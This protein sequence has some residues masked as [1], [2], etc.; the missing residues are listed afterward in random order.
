MLQQEKNIRT[1]VEALMKE[2]AQRLQQLK[3]LLEQDQ[4]LCDVLCSA[5]YGVAPDCVPS[6]EQLENFH[7]HISNQKAEKVSD[8]VISIRYFTT[9]AV[10]PL[11][12]RLFVLPG[13]TPRRVHRAE[14]A[15]HR[16]HGGAGP[17]PRDQLREGRGLRERR[18][19]LPLQREHNVS[20]AA[21]LSGETVVKG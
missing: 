10:A 17:H 16:L 20:E 9:S 11:R 18:L 1:Q 15:D 14:E 3:A 8:S 21:A 13:E 6:L 12:S 19:F 4:D 5:P 7:Q 2:K